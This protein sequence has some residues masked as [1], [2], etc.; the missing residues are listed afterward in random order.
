MAVDKKAV[1]A[2]NRKSLFKNP[3]QKKAVKEEVM[4]IADINQIMNFIVDY[5][6]PAVALGELGLL[7][8]VG[9]RF[10]ESDEKKMQRYFKSKKK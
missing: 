6:A 2:V 9:K 3:Q 7:G 1:A 8:Y 4:K 10:F 5:G